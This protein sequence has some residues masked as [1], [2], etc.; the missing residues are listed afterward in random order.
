MILII[1]S[2]AAAKSNRLLKILVI[3]LILLFLGIKEVK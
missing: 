2:S 1:D 3:H